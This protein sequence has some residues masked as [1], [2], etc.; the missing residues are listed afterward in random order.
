MGI[1][2][3]GDTATFRA[4]T[5]FT[6]STE[7]EA[8]FGSHGLFWGHSVTAIVQVHHFGW[9]IARQLRI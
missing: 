9:W 5:G 1:I 4:T 6:G 2:G 8:L 3:R 7:L